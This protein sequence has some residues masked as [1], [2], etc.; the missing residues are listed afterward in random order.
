MA[1][2]LQA[3]PNRWTYLAAKGAINILTK[4]MALD[5]TPGKVRVNSVSPSWIWTP[6]TAKASQGVVI[7][8]LSF[9]CPN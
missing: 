1:A 3:Q 6:E 9:I 5:M 4:A 8:F 2:F 7:N